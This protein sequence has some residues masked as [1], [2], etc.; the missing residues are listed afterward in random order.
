MESYEYKVAHYQLHFSHEHW[1]LLTQETFTI[2]Q[3]TMIDQALMP[4]FIMSIRMVEVL[5]FLL[6][7]V[8]DSDYCLE[9]LQ[10]YLQWSLYPLESP[11]WSK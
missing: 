9:Y 4:I 2:L 6:D 7:S 1:S 10:F 3:M 5:Y 8:H 11:L